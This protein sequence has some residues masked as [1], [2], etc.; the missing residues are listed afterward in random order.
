MGAFMSQTELIAKWFGLAA[1]LRDGCLSVLGDAKIKISEPLEENPELF[2]YLLFC[3]TITNFKGAISLFQQGLII[4]GQTLQRSCFENSIWLRRL[5]HEGPAFAKAIW[6][7]GRFNEGSFAAVLVPGTQ[8]LTTL[9]QIEGHVEAGKGMKRIN[10]KDGQSLDGASE[11]YAE[12][13]RLSMSAAHPSSTSLLRHFATND[14]T[15]E[16]EIAVEVVV[17]ERELA[18]NL[19]FTMAAML[20]TLNSFAECLDLSGALAV[21]NAMAARFVQ[22]QMQSGLGE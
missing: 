4:E 15:G 19:F 9:A 10:A 14:V 17:D 21:R 5:A 16:L 22:L 3:R 12:F 18:T 13:R 11:D 7:D 6:D 1:D 20:N 8:D 2:G